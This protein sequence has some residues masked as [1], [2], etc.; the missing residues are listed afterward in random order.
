MGD[1][2][3]FSRAHVLDDL[4]LDLAMSSGPETAL[5]VGCGEGRFAACSDNGASPSAASIPYRK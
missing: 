2:G 4:M 3:D 1:D 5:D